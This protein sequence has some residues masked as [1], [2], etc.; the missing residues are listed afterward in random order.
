MYRSEW[1]IYR[2]RRYCWLLWEKGVL[3]QN[4]L[5]R[6]AS[7]THYWN[8]CSF[9]QMSLLFLIVYPYLFQN[10]HFNAVI[11]QRSLECLYIKGEKRVLNANAE[12]DGVRSVVQ[13]VELLDRQWDRSRTTRPLLTFLLLCFLSFLPALQFYGFCSLSNLP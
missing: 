1:N 11:F 12:R 10:L 2:Q 3:L 4:H 13:S 5:Q 9:L 7:F 6:F 8:R